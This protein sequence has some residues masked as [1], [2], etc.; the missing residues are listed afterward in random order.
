M[1]S[2]LDQNHRLDAGGSTH[3]THETARIADA[4]DV[5]QDAMRLLVGHQIVENFA[6]VHIGG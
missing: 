1:A 3:G 5:Q 6:K 4:F 2:H